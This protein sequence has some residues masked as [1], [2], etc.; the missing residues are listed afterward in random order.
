MGTS[1]EEDQWEERR[2]RQWEVAFY[3]QPDHRI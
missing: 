1:G 3:Y 2:G